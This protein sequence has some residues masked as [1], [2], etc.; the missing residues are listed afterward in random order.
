MASRY[1]FVST[2]PYA[3]KIERGLSPQAPDGVYQ[4][5]A[6]LAQKRFGNVARIRFSYRALPGVE[7]RQPAIIIQIGGRR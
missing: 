5:V 1:E 4:V 3:R 7:G 2:V 6:V